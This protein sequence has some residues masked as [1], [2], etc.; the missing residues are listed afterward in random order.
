MNRLKGFVV[1][2]TVAA[3][4]LM[5]PS[6]TSAQ[7]DPR[8]S[9]GSAG[10]NA[11]GER[12]GGMAGTG[13]SG[14]AV[15]SGG[16]GGGSS[17][18]S[19]G[20]SS[21]WSGGGS[22]NG[23][24]ASSGGWSDG[25]RGTASRRL[26][27][28]AR[29][30]DSRRNGDGYSGAQSLPT[31]SRSRGE[32][33]PMGA[34]GSRRYENSESGGAAVPWFTRSRGDRQPTGTAA[35]RADSGR[36]P[37]SGGGGGGYDYWNGN[38]GAWNYYYPGYFFSSFRDCYPVGFGAFGLGYF[39]Y[40]PYSWTYRGYGCSSYG[41]Y[42]YG[43]YGGAGY[44]GGYMYPLFDTSNYGGV[45]RATSYGESGIKLKIKPANAQVFVDGYFAGQVDEFDGTFQRL[46]VTPGNH[47]LEVKA[48]GYE[49][50]SFEVRVDP[51]QTVTYKGELQRIQ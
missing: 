3:V 35:G 31:F 46:A 2:L 22:S 23:G 11:A 4:G 26:D 36:P 21:T 34:E 29:G 12:G 45:G 5:F 28:G 16:S 51:F 42:G 49:P 13:G 32:H 30:G 6:S 25:A 38:I 47:R 39:Y 20:S 50:L 27:V 10:S 24:G 19:G 44:Y 9:A 1:V 18:S 8:G 43:A 15:N 17:T 37:V 7:G 33:S 40:D 41:Y 14:G 48:T